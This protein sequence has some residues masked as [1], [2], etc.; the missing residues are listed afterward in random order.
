MLAYIDVAIVSLLAA[1]MCAVMAGLVARARTQAGFLPPAVTGN[2]EVERKIRA[3]QNTI[4]WM[5]AYLVGLWLFAIY[6][7][8][9]WAAAL[10]MVWIVGRIIYFAGYSVAAEKRL[11]GFG[12]QALAATALVL[13]ALGRVIFLV[14]ATS[15]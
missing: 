7:N 2:A 1:V 6:W 5:P 13:G 4:E 12:I 14:V 10:G 8:S 11:L 3:H 15:R 9:Q